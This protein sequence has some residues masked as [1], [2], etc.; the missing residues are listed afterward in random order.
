MLIKSNKI[1]NL[2]VTSSC[3]VILWFILYS[4]NDSIYRNIT[5]SEPV[6]YYFVWHQ[7][8]Y[9]VH[10]LVLVCINEKLYS[11]VLHQLGLPKVN[12]ECQNNMPFLLKRIVARRGDI[13]RYTADGVY[14]NGILHKN[15]K[16]VMQYHGIKLFPQM[17]KVYQLK[18]NE[19]F[20]LGE[21][22]TSYDSRYFGVITQNQIY[23]KAVLI[24]I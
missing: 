9:N 14:I 1:K 21:T 18:N 23:K 24:H 11:G 19:F 10:D 22:K 17:N 3:V 12:S 8:T 2:M 15:S 6:G 13:I 5:N 16:T 4:L 7:S 20:L